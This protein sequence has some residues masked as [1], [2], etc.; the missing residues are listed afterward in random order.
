MDVLFRQVGSA[1]STLNLYQIEALEVYGQGGDDLLIAGAL[2]NTSLR[3]IYFEG[4]LGNDT[5]DGAAS[6]I[7][8]TADGGDGADSLVG[9]TGAD[10]LRGAG[11]ADVLVGGRGGDLLDGGS[12]DDRFIWTFGDGG[13][14]IIGGADND[15]L[16]IIGTT[17]DDS[18]TLRVDG[19]QV[20]LEFSGVASD[21]L[22]I[23]EVEAIEV[24]G[25]DGDDLLSV[26]VL[27]STTVSK[28]VFD[29]GRGADI[30]DGSGATRAV[31]ARGSADDDTLIGGAGNDSLAGGGDDD[32]LLGAGGADTLKGNTGDDDIGGGDGADALNGGLGDDTLNGGEGADDIYGGAGEDLIWGAS[33]ADVFRFSAAELANGKE[34][35][36]IIVDYAAAQG[37]EVDLPQGLSSVAGHYLLND[38]LV[39]VLQGDGDTIEFVG[40]HDIS[41]IIFV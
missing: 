23:R 9:G 34:E 21:A 11:G 1:G 6:T 27:S 28:V 32:V 2:T 31:E 5:L 16:Q 14:R 25:G 33:G 40:V 20:V 17:A 38:K 26:G 8:L 3:Q 7:A 37:D 12:G 15:T 18:L 35:G 41:D 30:L 36:D 4:G 19:N 39:V 29:G 22:D 24:T 13:D 10:T